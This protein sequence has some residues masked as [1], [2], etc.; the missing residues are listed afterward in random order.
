MMQIPSLVLT[1]SVG[2]FI[3]TEITGAGSVNKPGVGTTQKLISSWRS[4]EPE[5]ELLRNGVTPSW[6]WKLPGTQFHA[7]VAKNCWSR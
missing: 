5:P 4:K 2:A 3:G 1:H 6:N 7:E